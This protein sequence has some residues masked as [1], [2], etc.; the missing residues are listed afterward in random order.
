M[1]PLGEHGHHQK[2]V[3]D[4]SVPGIAVAYYGPSLLGMDNVGWSLRFF[5]GTPV[6]RVTHLP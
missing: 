1:E 6:L 5:I 3:T 2:L 4:I